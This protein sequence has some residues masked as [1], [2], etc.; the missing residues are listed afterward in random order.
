MLQVSVIGNLG[1]D[2]QVKSKNG[3]SFLCF[4][5]AH[6]ARVKSSN[7]EMIDQ[8]QW[9]S[10]TMN[11]YSENF[12]KYLVRGTKVYVYGKL[13][14]RIWRDNQGI[15]NV[16]LNVL[17]DIVELCGSK[18]DAAQSAAAPADAPA[19]PPA[20]APAAPAAKSTSAA[21]P[22]KKNADDLPF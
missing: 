17:A 11:H 5:V 1:A 9:V 18:A 21:S 6:T 2:A 15:S 22:G 19:A 12:A 14:S 4:N 20:D 10:V 16:G 7:G 13:F 3:N 8:T